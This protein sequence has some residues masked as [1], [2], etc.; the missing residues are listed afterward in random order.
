MNK[1]PDIQKNEGRL[2]QALRAVPQEIEP[3]RDLWAGIE[4]AVAKTP[5][6]AVDDNAKTRLFD[7]VIWS[8]VAA[9]VLPVALVTGLLLKEP[10]QP[11][12]DM[13]WLEPTVASY[14][15]QKQQLLRQVSD[16]QPLSSNY[17]ATMQDLEQAEQALKKA[18][19]TQP[20]DPALMRMLNSVY[21]QQLA[22]IAKSH[23]PTL[24][25]I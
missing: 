4:Q 25:Q 6:E 13:P 21:Q 7:V 2:E 18:L 22:L 17:Q 8:K 19:L 3:K 16:G 14:E 24:N 5:Q 12:T 1:Q 10:A 23:Q 20:G 9:A 15:L 11:A